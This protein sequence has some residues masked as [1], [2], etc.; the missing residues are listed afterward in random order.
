MRYNCKLPRILPRPFGRGEGCGEGVPPCVI[1]PTLVP[2][3]S[4]AA[5]AELLA[6]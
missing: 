4:V 1:H 3:W 2:K 6:L 5:D